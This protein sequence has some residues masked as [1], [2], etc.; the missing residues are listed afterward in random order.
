MHGGWGLGELEQRLVELR[1]SE[2]ATCHALQRPGAAA[3]GQRRLRRRG[4]ECVQIALDLGARGADRR[5]PGGSAASILVSAA[6]SRGRSTAPRPG[7]LPSADD[8]LRGAASHVDDGDRAASGRA[9][10]RDRPEER[11]VPLFC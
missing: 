5:A 7:R 8:D 9:G 4:V 2:A 6:A 11:K 1:S 10:A 3:H